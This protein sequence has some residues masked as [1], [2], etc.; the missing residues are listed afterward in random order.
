MD[1]E[2]DID[3]ENYEIEFDD[4]LENDTEQLVEDEEFALTYP[5][6]K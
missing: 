1:D 2:E 3:D 6:L 5:K 4:E